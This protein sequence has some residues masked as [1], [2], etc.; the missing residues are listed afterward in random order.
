MSPYLLTSSTGL[1]NEDW[2]PERSDLYAKWE[3]VARDESH[4]WNAPF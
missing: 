3:L 2:I 1:M 4:L